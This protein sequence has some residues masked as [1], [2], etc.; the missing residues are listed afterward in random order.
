MGNVI[1]IDYNAI[2][3]IMDIYQI[4]KDLQKYVF[5]QVLKCFTWSIEI[6]K[7]SKPKGSENG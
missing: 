6:V 2:Q 5:N 3:T 1:G 4:D 7:N